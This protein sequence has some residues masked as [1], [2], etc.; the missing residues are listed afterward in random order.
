MKDLENIC[1]SVEHDFDGKYQSV[2]PEIVQ[3]SSFQFQNFAHY[4]HVNTDHEF[5]YTYTRGDNPTL[6]ILEKKI[7][8]LEGAEC[9]R[10]FASGMG[11]IS[12][13]ILSLVKKGDHIIIVNT[14]YGSSV[15][16]IQQLQKFGVESTKIDVQ[17][18]KEIFEYMK[19]ETKM[20][21]FE[22]P[23]SQ[24]FEMLDLEMIANVAKEKNIYTVIDNTWATPLLQNPLKYGIDVV[25]HSCSKYI[26]GHSDIV[27]GIVLCRQEIM[28]YIDDFA[29]ILLGA[30]MS[31]MN[32][33]LAVRGLRTLPVRLKAQEKS[34]LDVIDFLRNDPRI[35]RIF[36][37]TCNGEMQKDLANR[38]LKGYG[39]LLGVVLK[40][41][42]PTIIESFVDA[43]HHF[44]LAYSWGGFESLILPVF[45]GNNQ[46]ELE[47]RGLALGQLRMY[48]GLEETEILIEDLK[49]SLD[50]AYQVK[51]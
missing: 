28:K 32:A 22:S 1:L 42:N 50:I 30:T 41:A 14:V 7:A 6:E 10:S 35:E 4:V 27:G 9:G 24:R 20:I 13:T 26:G 46:D 21:Y 37:P 5:A 8:H 44:T 12:G 36:H 43:L 40:D 47:A 2:A 31:P 25:I 18:T 17:E 51:M 15:K 38:Y 16:L 19:P 29:H 23:S 34:V 33:W 3:T 49:Q 39:S 11:A 48:I 45:K